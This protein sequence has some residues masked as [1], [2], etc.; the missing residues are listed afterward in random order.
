MRCGII[1]TRVYSVTVNSAEPGFLA[2]PSF[3]IDGIQYPVAIFTDG[4]YAL[5]TGAISGV[6]SRPAKPGDILTLYGVGFGPVTPT[7]PAGQ[8]VQQLNML[9]LPF[10][11]SI[12]GVPATPAY[13][14]LAPNY[15]GLYQFDVTVPSAAS[16]N[17][18]LT[19]TL[20]G[21]PGTQTLYI[22]VGN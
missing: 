1:R 5:P 7:I 19:F 12:G 20:G 3:K 9:S 11:I 18:A 14:G 4:A 6:T 21:T 10:E 2:P 13:D 16:G 17:A 8:V 22:A 15:T